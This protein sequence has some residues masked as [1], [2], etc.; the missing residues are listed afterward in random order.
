MT[1]V[2]IGMPCFNSSDYLKEAIESLISQSFEDF[3]LMIS[4]NCSS[5]NS[6]EIASEYAAKDSRIVAI[7]QTR[8]KGA[9]ANFKFLAEKACSEF[10][11]FAGSHDCWSKNYLEALYYPLKQDPSVV[12]SYAHLS[13][14]RPC[15][16]IIPCLNADEFHCLE[17]E[18]K[19]RASKVVRGLQSCHMIYG[20]LRTA[21]LK[22]TRINLNCIGPDHVI[23][24]EFALRGKIVYCPE[25]TLF[26][27]QVREEPTDE[28]EFRRKQLM[29]ITGKD[30]VK[31]ELKNRYRH[32]W[33]QHLISSFNVSG[34]LWQR[35]NNAREISRA[36]ID[37]WTYQMPRYISL[38]YRLT[39]PDKRFDI[40][41]FFGR[42]FFKK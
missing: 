32:W 10:F 5:D 36:F 9:A 8:N 27:R 37:R 25:A 39:M 31:K 3:E 33:L 40:Y 28:M 7:K 19:M 26:M 22:R 16:E 11:M 14:L 13:K 20:L 18:P 23:L 29:R 30:D 38:P 35:C 34:S 2:S 41:S 6:Y 42:C 21:D 15:G 24:S 17:I 1:A 12:I 4:D